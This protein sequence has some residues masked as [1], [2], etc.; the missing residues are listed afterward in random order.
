MASV[1]YSGDVVGHDRTKADP[2]F[3]RFDFDQRF[4]SEQTSAAGAN[5]LYALRFK[6]LSNRIRTQR[7]RRHIGGNKG[8]SLQQFRS[9]LCSIFPIE[10]CHRFAVNQCSRTNGTQA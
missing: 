6:R 10:R 1:E 3:G 4:D 7:N 2:A 8:A 9:N 5:D